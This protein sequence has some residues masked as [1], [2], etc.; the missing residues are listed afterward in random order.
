MSDLEVLQ[1]K[2]GL[3]PS[4]AYDQATQAAV[5]K[6]QL[7]HKLSPTGEPDP[8]TLASAGV[9]DPMEA[10]PKDLQKKST[11]GRDLMT[12]VNQVP[13][14]AWF[15]LAALSGG[16]AFVAYRRRNPKAEGRKRRR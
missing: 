9:Y 13:Y 2:L 3:A 5:V 1:Q 10:A 16:I 12:A 7:A 15:V 8:P 11:L 14:W 6:F 4:S